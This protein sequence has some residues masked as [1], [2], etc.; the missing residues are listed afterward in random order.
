MT[1][2]NV[3]DSAGAGPTFAFVNRTVGGAFVG[4]M[5]LQLAPK[6]EAEA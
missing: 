2:I 4:P 5:L 1:L 3:S 6:S